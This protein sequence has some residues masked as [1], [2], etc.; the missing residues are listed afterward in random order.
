MTASF[1]MRFFYIYTVVQLLKLFIQAGLW[2]FCHKIY[3]NNK[4]LFSTKGSLLIVAN[5]PNS[6]LDALVI[7]SFYKRRVYFLARGD[8]FKKP[9]HR[10]LLESLNMI[11]VYRLRE[12]KEFL[13]LNDYA[14]TKSIQLL[15]KGEAV[16]I[17]IE[18]ICL[19]TNELQPFKK[20]TARIIEGIQK[21]HIHPIIH[22]AGIS[23]N[24]FRGIG[25]KINLIITEYRNY[26]MIQNGRDRVLFNQSIF[27]KLNK[28]IIVINETTKINNN[29]IFYYIHLPYY[30]MIKKWVD[31]KTK[32]TVFY[33]SVLFVVLLFSYP[34]YLLFL[35]LL[36]SLF[37]IPIFIILSTLAIIPV[38]G[39]RIVQ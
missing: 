4:Q 24:Q 12:G 30:N 29:N 18:G 19:N 16:L 7:G 25:K 10:F 21:Q 26:P 27:E 33:D 11:P 9:I 34:V 37:N 28:N 22:I 17:F 20:G 23:F 13:H 38:M 3:L 1:V 31:Q 8:A 15:S 39:K 35:Y 2:L 5:H 14:F 36:L 32:N 6:F